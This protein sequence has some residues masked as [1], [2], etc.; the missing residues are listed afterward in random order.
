MGN[1]ELFYEG[2]LE[3]LA[4]DV[5]AIGG[6]KVVGAMFNPDLAVEQ[7]RGWCNDRLNPNRRER[8]T[9]T[10]ERHVMRLAREKR[11]F[12]AALYYL[13]DDT[14]FERPKANNPEDERAE[15]Q[16]K[17]IEAVGIVER[18]GERLQ[19]VNGQ[20]SVVRAVVK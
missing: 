3:A 13:C 7:A 16:R 5:K 15:L 4:D 19:S 2:W 11:G 9:D 14:G 10:Q 8:F 6:A 12:S 18:L 17:F 20:V 1:P